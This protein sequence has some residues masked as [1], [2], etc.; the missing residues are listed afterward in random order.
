[1][2]LQTKLVDTLAQDPA[3]RMESVPDHEL[4]S[5]RTTL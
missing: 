3:L 2:P 4:S 1:M 5:V